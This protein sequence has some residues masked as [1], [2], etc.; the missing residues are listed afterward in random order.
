LDM[1]RRDWLRESNDTNLRLNDLGKTG[2]PQ[3]WP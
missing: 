1:R 2:I 3:L